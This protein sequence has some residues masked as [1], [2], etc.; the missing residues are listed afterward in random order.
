[1]AFLLSQLLTRSA[2]KNRSKEA[3]DGNQ[4]SLTYGELDELSNRLARSLR[5]RGVKRGDRVAIYLD[6]SIEAVVSIFA[7]L[8]ADATYVPLDPGAPV[9]R[10]AY[11]THNS[12]ARVLVSSPSKQQRI[13]QIF[14]EDQSME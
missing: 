10:L 6:K 7:V 13:E 8:K 11:I 9:P 4:R 3:L 2:A 12:E 14:A 5:H 1:M